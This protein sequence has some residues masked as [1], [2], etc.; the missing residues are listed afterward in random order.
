VRGRGVPEHPRNLRWGEEGS[1]PGTRRIH[2][3]GRDQT[4]RGGRFLFSRFVFSSFL[5]PGSGPVKA[6][7]HPHS[8]KES[9]NFAHFF[10]SI[11]GA[12]NGQTLAFK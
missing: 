11:Y 5:D 8:M 9:P 6:Y 12:F 10:S 3:Q 4:A 2:Q 7:S 1:G